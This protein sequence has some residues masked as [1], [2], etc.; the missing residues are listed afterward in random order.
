MRFLVCF[1]ALLFLAA[2]PEA[3]AQDGQPSTEFVAASQSPAPDH[4]SGPYV[5]L[6]SDGVQAIF[7]SAG[8][9]RRDG[10]LAD[11]VFL[12]VIAAPDRTLQT[13][14]VRMAYD[15]AANTG[16]ETG[17]TQ[18]LA[19]GPLRWISAQQQMTP[20]QREHITYAALVCHGALPKPVAAEFAGVLNYARGPLGLGKSGQGRHMGAFEF[21]DLA[22]R[23]RP[24][25]EP[26]NAGELI[27]EFPWTNVSELDD[28]LISTALPDGT[29][30]LRCKV[31]QGGALT[32][33]VADF[34]APAGRGLSDAA[35]DVASRLRMRTDLYDGTSAVG[36]YIRLSI[37][38]G[39]SGFGATVY[40]ISRTPLEPFY[41]Q[42]P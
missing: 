14:T 36:R 3:S 5:L 42:E 32:G 34:E 12:I 27:R 10:N 17:A 38:H 8:N 30:K 16:R 2:A 35:L 23:P 21:P 6:K 28:T 4:T 11:A 33:C 20:N 40:S 26:L 15:C 25:T 9:V 24:F 7:L 1:C 18:A 22:P 31:A 29:V 39:R 13:A 37:D 41:P 19:G